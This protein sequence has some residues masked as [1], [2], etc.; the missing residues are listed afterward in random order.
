MKVKTVEV[1]SWGENKDLQKGSLISS[2]R[3]GKS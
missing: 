3:N 1:N 2:E